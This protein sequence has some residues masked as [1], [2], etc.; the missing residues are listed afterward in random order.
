VTIFRRLDMT[1]ETPAE[2]AKLD[3]IFAAWQDSI[4]PMVWNMYN[5]F[6]RT[7]FNKEQAL[8]LTK[9]MWI[10]TRREA[11]KHKRDFQG[12]P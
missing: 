1:D 10:E 6:L 4:P 12:E 11:D 2:R 3:Q 5:G 7:G 9:F 8:D